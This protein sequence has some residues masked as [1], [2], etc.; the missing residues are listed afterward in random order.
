MLIFQGVYDYE[1]PLLVA[2][3]GYGYLLKL[4]L[5]T[6]TKAMMDL[7]LGG[8]VEAPG[9][10]MPC[11]KSTLPKPNTAPENVTVPKEK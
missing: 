3:E 10:H 2:Q 9:F 11:D 6:L 1:L 5:W 8:M 7:V 4:K